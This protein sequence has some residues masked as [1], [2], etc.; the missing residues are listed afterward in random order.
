VYAR[1]RQT[2]ISL[3]HSWAYGDHPVLA[4]PAGESPALRCRIIEGSGEHRF[5]ASDA[6]S[7]ND[8]FRAY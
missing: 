7:C 6:Q 8:A 2:S 3:H 5:D 4:S 1:S